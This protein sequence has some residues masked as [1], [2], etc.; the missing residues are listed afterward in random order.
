VHVT[1]PDADKVQRGQLLTL[2]LNEWDEVFS[3]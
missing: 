3:D 1:H 2:K